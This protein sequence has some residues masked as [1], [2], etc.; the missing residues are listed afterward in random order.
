MELMTALRIF[1]QFYALS[2]I[3]VKN[4]NFSGFEKCQGRIRKKNLSNFPKN[5]ILSSF[6]ESQAKPPLENFFQEN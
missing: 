5:P 4:I 2:R 6:E 1:K 3:V